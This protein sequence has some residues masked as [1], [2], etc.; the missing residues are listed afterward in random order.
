HRAALRRAEEDLRAL[1]A[2]LEARVRLRTAELETAYAFLNSVIHHIPYHVNVKDAVDLKL[3]RVN[4]ALEQLTGR[5]QQELLG[6]TVHDFISSKEE[7]DFF[8]AKDKEA[9]ALG[10]EVDIPEETLHARDGSVRVL[11]AKKIPILDEAG[12]PRYLLTISED[13][14][15]RK[16]KEREI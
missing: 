14:T 6:K 2:D 3:I 16:M 11:H 9:L 1:N 10:R 8:T 7:A 12:Q 15:E 13:V 4:R 5:S